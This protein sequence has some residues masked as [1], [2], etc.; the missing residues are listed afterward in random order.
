MN[1]QPE[2]AEVVDRAVARYVRTHRQGSM[3]TVS[4]TILFE[5]LRG[6]LANGT[7]TAFSRQQLRAAMAAHPAWEGKAFEDTSFN[8]VP[9]DLGD[10][11]EQFVHEDSVAGR[12]YR[13]RFRGPTRKFRT[14]KASTELFLEIE[15]EPL[16]PVAKP[17]R[18]RW[19]IGAAV[20][21]VAIAIGIA[22]WMRPHRRDTTVP[23]T[24]TLAVL[25]FRFIGSDE[26]LRFL[27]T[28]IADAMITRLSNVDVVR[29]RPTTSILRY[30][31]REN[32]LQSVGREL[33]ADY[34]VS[35]T[36]QPAG[37]RLRATAQLVRMEDGTAI[38][39]QNFDV[40][41]GELLTLEDNIADRV[42][43]ALQPR[44][45]ADQRARLAR[46]F[47]S[48]PAAFEHYLHGRASMLLLTRSGTEDAV[49][50]FE[51]AIALDPSY[52]LARAGLASSAAQMRIRFAPK[53]DI[54]KWA[55]LAREQAEEAAREAPD[56]GETHEAL[57][58]VYR[59]DEFDWEKVIEESDKA[60]AINPDL[61]LPHDYRAAAAMH[62][63][64][65][66][67]A[68]REARKAMEINPQRPVEA[69]RILGACAMFEG[70]FADSLTL[71]REV[72][73]RT[74][75]ADYYYGLVFFY[76]GNVADAEKVLSGLAGGATRNARAAAALS[77]VLAATN[78]KAQ[79]A[80]I[81]ANAIAR[82]PIDH[83][84]AYSLGAT[85]AQLGDAPKALHWLEQ[86]VSSGF[87]C[88]P[89]FARD[90]LL[91]PL[92]DDAR[93]KS[94]LE[95]LRIQNDSWTRRYGK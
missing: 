8:T 56:L 30:A 68:E 64:L 43:V 87:P 40:P 23:R 2:L 10:Q 24:A 78:R 69:L 79:A 74:D 34:L 32:D 80:T 50:E 29:V 17:A 44:L 73:V 49:R 35:G 9:E 38:W 4:A 19:V 95:R 82:S 67:V 42:A 66:P 76:T 45:T 81:V 41:R 85:Y 62:F 36:L 63:G 70:R 15:S 60:I 58:A 33:G 7:K 51:S 1:P 11:L 61:E 6:D 65:L 53:S 5:A 39:G 18:Y 75:I 26:Q 37:D 22:V 14:D 31:N 16:D 12:R 47:T 21:A 94:M 83:H 77:S 57:A 84:V 13:F 52:A 20:L 46:R 28:G 71:L 92:R 48:N 54:A 91:Q 25:P 89:W 93:F 88:Y 3:A 86:S 90:P 55:A 59:Y 72:A 27:G